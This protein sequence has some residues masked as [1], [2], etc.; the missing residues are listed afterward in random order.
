MTLSIPTGVDSIVEIKIMTV[1][2]RF[3]VGETYSKQQ[4][5]EGCGYS[6]DATSVAIGAM[7]KIKAYLP[8]EK[9]HNNQVW[10]YHKM[11]IKRIAE[12]LFEVISF[13]GVHHCR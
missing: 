7:G 9:A 10:A 3:K 11:T 1:E 2:T 4:L 6:K 5:F 8:N 12:D 13:D